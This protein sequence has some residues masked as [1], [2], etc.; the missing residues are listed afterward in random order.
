M[1]SDEDLSIAGVANAASP[2]RGFEINTMKENAMRSMIKT[3]LCCIT[4]AVSM[5]MAYAQQ[6]IEVYKNAN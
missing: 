2:T 3:F 1:R 4:L 5:P 6:T